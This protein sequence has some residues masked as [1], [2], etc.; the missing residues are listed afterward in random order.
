MTNLNESGARTEVG[1]HNATG[2]AMVD[3]PEAERTTLGKELKEEIAE[4]RRKKLACFQKTRMGVI[5]KTVPAITTMATTTS[6]V[7]PNLTPEEL[8]KFMD[9]AVARKYGNDLMNF[10]CTITEGV[11]STLYTFQTD[12]QSTLLQQIDK[13]CSRFSLS[14]RLDNQ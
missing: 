2:V 13:W 3:P 5:K 14:H 6:T 12:L 8:V 7:T 10:T 9:V 11:H 4:A 1:P